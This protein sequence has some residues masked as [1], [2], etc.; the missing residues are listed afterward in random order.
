MLK[1]PLSGE[2]LTVKNS[3][4]RVEEAGCGAA[5]TDFCTDVTTSR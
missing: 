2:P 5:D 3:R 1:D 4:L